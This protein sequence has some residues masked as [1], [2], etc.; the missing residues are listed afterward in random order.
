[1]A[2]SPMED[3]GGLQAKAHETH[4]SWEHHFISTARPCQ[5]AT[6]AESDR[7]CCIPGCPQGLIGI[8][9]K[10]AFSEFYSWDVF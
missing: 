8:F 9:Y 5:Q 3:P 6:G 7:H 4:E 10:A 2:L 1:M